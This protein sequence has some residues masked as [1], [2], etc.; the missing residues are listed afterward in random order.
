[1][2]VMRAIVMIG[3]PASGKSDYIK[4]QL[5]RTQNK[6]VVCP[7]DIRAELTGNAGDQSKNAE[8][9][10]L[11]YDR[12]EKALQDGKVLVFD[13]TNAKKLDRV[14]LLEFLRS[15]MGPDGFIKGVWMQTPLEVCL[16][17]IAKRDRKVPQTS[18]ERMHHA[19]LA[20]PPRVYEGFDQLY[21]PTFA[22][23]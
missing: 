8:V 18:M 19:L 6:C 13:A 14:G 22:L 3:I 9:W 12:A 15:V 20:D 7:D 21:V 4:Y 16:E 10:K 5:A 2:S 1:M 11:A 23:T 17:R